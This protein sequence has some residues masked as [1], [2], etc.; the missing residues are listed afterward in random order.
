MKS[1]TYLVK[2]VSLR[3]RKIDLLLFSVGRRDQRLETKI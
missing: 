3:V 1:Q 2:G